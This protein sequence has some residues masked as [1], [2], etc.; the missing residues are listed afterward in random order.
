MDLTIIRHTSVDVVKG[1]IYGQ[2]DVPV[3]ETFLEEAELVKSKLKE[4]E[5]DTIFSSPLTRCKLLTEFLFKGREVVFD[6]H[7]KEL[8]F[9]DWEGKN[10]N[11]IEQTDVAQNWFKS[12]QTMPVPGGESNLILQERVIQWYEGVREKYENKK[13]V[14]ICHGGPIKVLL[15]H[16]KGISI[17]EQ[18]AQ[19][20]TYGDVIE[21][22][23]NKVE[24]K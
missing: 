3:K 24:I 10:W 9:G 8:F 6:E 17:E 20:I 18:F 22:I 19:A 1:T 16:I 7:L 2:T 4:S 12:W 11:D 14:A 23:D 13:V 5:Y 21:I 15:A